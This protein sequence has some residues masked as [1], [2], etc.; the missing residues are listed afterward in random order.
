MARSVRGGMVV[1]YREAVPSDPDAEAWFT[2]V[3]GN[4]GT[5]SGPRREL[6]TTLI[7]GLKTDG[8]WS[9]LDRLWVLAAENSPSARTDMKALDL[10]TAVNS[11]TF[12]ADRGYTGI[13]A[14]STRLDLSYN[15]STDGI[16]LGASDASLGVWVRVLDGAGTSCP[17]GTSD[18]ANEL[19]VV[20]DVG[21]DRWTAIIGTNIVSTSPGT[22]P[23]GLISASQLGT[24]A[25]SVR[26]YLNGSSSGNISGA[27]STMP[28]REE[29]G[30]CENAGTPTLFSD[31]QISAIFFGGD[32]TDAQMTNLYSRLQ[33]YMTAVGA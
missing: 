25:G 26:I 5:V 9:Q 32:L 22:R 14:S 23:T 28:N 19:T 17:V 10:A 18:G 27:A 6:V 15:P 12:T 20:E 24:G 31:A 2:A 21:V 8:V 16:N 7:I 30:L 13:S 33:T 1:G 4:G 29:S 11:P 3:E